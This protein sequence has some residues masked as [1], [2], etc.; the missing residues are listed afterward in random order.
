MTNKQNTAKK[1]VGMAL[2]TALV[3]G[4]VAT[5]AHADT[6]KPAENTQVQKA[7]AQQVNV[8][9]NV[10]KPVVT[11]KK[12]QAIGGNMIDH[13]QVSA[14]GTVNGET[15]NYTNN[16]QISDTTNIN[17]VGD[18]K[19][20]FYIDDKD[21]YG[22]VLKGQATGTV[23]VVESGKPV[24]TL[25]KGTQISAKVGD[26]INPADF[27]TATDMEDGNLINDVEVF[28]NGVFT[29]TF[30]KAGNAKV[31]FAVSD[32]DGNFAEAVISAV[33][34]EVETEKPETKPEEKP[35][36]EKPTEKPAEKP[37]EKPEVEKPE[38]EKPVE[39]PE[40]EKPVER[41]ETGGTV[42]KK[43]DST[44]E[45]S[46]K[47]NSAKEESKKDDSTK[48]ESKKDN[49]T[50]EESKKDNLVVKKEETVKSNDE[51]INKEHVN[52]VKE[53]GKSNVNSG[54]TIT[55]L[56]QTGEADSSA[57]GVGIGSILAGFALTFG[58]KTKKFFNK[59]K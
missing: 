18:Y 43:D 49:S 22:N 55:E 26:T 52:P 50:K 54:N 25:K 3:T 41:P 16:L 32:S 38:T 46:K 47:D 17:K 7:V 6:L 23:K 37:A 12:G 45:E 34:S 48:E 4:A 27:I 28:V 1:V 20:T 44:E 19:V 5:H 57:M 35:E 53:D 58:R 24:I 14:T 42:D 56:P 8:K 2:A 40:T 11:I 13:M 10:G 21:D 30:N 36:T 31:T 33:V 15:K 51:N 39:K 29:D 59:N 9:I